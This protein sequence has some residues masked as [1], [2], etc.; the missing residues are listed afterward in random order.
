M[1]KRYVFEETL[2]QK[3]ESHSSELIKELNN[4]L[5]PLQLWKPPPIKINLNATVMGTDLHNVM[6][7]HAVYFSE[8]KMLFFQ[9]N[10][11]STH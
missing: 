9:I 6:V 10:L 2:R 3:Q 1:E 8:Q 4:W 5:P 7:T 11:K